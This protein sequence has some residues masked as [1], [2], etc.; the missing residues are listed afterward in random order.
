MTEQELV[1]QARKIREKAYAP[2]SKFKV[3]AALRT[4]SGKVFSGVNVENI[5]YGLTIC[6]ERSAAVSAIT[7]G[8]TEWE[9][10]AVVA[11]TSL[12][13]TPC[14]ACRQF[15]AEFNINLPVTVANL[16]KIHFTTM[17]NQLLPSA[18]DQAT[19]QSDKEIQ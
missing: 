10:I 6:A 12:P 13:T 14:G 17:L 19:Y 18:F 16:E 9:A 4:K 11:D 7:A 1:N 2:Y 8:E 5:S 15:L 3:G